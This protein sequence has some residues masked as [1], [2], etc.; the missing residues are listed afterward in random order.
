MGNLAAERY[1]DE[2]ATIETLEDVHVA[3]SFNKRFDFTRISRSAK[4]YPASIILRSAI[5]LAL[6]T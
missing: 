5:R 4:R 1:R 3:F 6:T 2:G